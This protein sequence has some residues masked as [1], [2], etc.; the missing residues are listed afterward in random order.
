MSQNNPRGWYYRGKLPH[1]DGGEIC[2]F[3]TLHLGDAI[4]KKVIRSWKIE[5]EFEKNEDSKLELQ[6]RIEKYIDKGYGDC[7]LGESKIA[8]K[9]QDSLLHF[10]N[11]R[12]KIIDWVIMPNHIHF[13]FRPFKNQKLEK[14]MH[15][16]KSFTSQE[17]NR[18]LK[19]KGTFWQ[20]DYFDRFIRDYDH[21]TKT[22]NYIHNNPLK[23]GL[24]K[25]AK[26]WEFSS[27]NWRADTSVRS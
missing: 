10:H 27:I 21:Y 15:S 8:S 7:F 16:I 18:L 23:A 13:L 5:L 17:C 3:I 22:I 12:Y 11:K 6:R 25:D 9:V 2:Q 20:E 26:D 24:C 4:P 19:R 14:L 1:F